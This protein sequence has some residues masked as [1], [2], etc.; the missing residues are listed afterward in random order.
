MG[1]IMPYISCI[2]VG[3]RQYKDSWKLHSQL[4]IQHYRPSAVW[5]SQGQEKRREQT[6]E[7][8]KVQG[9][10]G[11]QRKRRILELGIFESYY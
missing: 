1:G 7:R 11:W 4:T 6:S 8:S 3:S 2:L 10:A 5:C 9:A